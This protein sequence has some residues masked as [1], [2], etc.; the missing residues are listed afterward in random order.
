MPPCSVLYECERPDMQ[1]NRN[2]LR[3][4]RASLQFL[5]LVTCLKSD[6]VVAMYMATQVCCLNTSNT[7]AQGATVPMALLVLV[8][9]AGAGC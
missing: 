6:K 1:M 3:I 4:E 2:K 8:L 5:L 7:N 9:G